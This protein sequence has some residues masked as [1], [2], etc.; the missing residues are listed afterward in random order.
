MTVKTIM[1]ARTLIN[2]KSPRKANK[3][4][5]ELMEIMIATPIVGVLG[6]LLPLILA[7]MYH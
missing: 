7:P 1:T 5:W 3:R 6:L 4:L 2:A